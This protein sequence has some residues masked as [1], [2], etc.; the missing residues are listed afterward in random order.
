MQRVSALLP[1]WD[2]RHSNPGSASILTNSPN[3]L[4]QQRQSDGRPT[5]FTK[6]FSWADR[7]ALSKG[8]SASASAAAG[9]AV[10]P[11]NSR[12]GRELYWPSTLDLECEKAARILKSFCS[13]SYPCF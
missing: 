12:V 2:R 11:A 13:T 9:A 10:D 6:V 5:G 3:T 7:L 1:S 4:H 8:A